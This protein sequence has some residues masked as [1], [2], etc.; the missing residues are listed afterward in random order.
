MNKSER[1]HQAHL[2]NMVFDKMVSNARRILKKKREE[3]EIMMEWLKEMEG[4]GML[5]YNVRIP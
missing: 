3:K 4:K 2:N 5:S 1:A